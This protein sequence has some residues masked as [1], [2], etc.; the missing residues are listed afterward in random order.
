MKGVEMELKE[1]LQE[2]MILDF[3]YLPLPIAGEPKKKASNSRQNNTEGEARAHQFEQKD[4]NRDQQ[5][6]Y[7]EFSQNRN[8]TEAQAWFKARDSDQNSSLSREEF[9]TSKVAN[10]PNLKK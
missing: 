8:P 2:K 3:D 10:P 4:L 1:A 7:E 5:L 9:V 6:S